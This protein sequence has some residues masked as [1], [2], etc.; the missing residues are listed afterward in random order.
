M[1]TLLSLHK[2]TKE[3]VD[4]SNPGSALLYLKFKATLKDTAESSNL[5][6][7]FK[8]MRDN[9]PIVI[10]SYELQQIQNTTGVN[11]NHSI[12]SKDKSSIVKLFNNIYSIQISWCQLI[13]LLLL[14]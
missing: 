12:E 14:A 7:P 6:L 11:I 8:G 10:A 2:V 13:L 5:V 3:A 4:Q 9:E 1:L